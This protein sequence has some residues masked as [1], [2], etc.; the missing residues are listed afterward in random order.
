MGLACRDRAVAFVSTFAAFLCRAYDHIRMGAVSH[1]N[2]NFFGSHCGISIGKLTAFLRIF[3]SGLIFGHGAFS[4]HAKRCGERV[5]FFAM[6][7]TLTY[8]VFSSHV[9]V[10]CTWYFIDLAWQLAGAGTKNRA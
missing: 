5:Y 6:F 9:F 4:L 7:S 8:K 10:F 1:T 2:C 3:L